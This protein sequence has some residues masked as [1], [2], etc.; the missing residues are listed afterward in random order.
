MAIN[1]THLCK[2]FQLEKSPNTQPVVFQREEVVRY[3]ILTEGLCDRLYFPKMAAT[4]S[5]PRPPTE[6]LC[7]LIQGILF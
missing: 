3:H 6:K 4:N 5:Y 7:K 1:P 2:I